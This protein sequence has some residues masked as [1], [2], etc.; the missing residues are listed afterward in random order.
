VQRPVDAEMVLEVMLRESREHLA[1]NRLRRERRTVRLQPNGA[2][3]RQ[4]VRATA[5]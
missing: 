2:Q 3:E 5:A 1:V 4:Y